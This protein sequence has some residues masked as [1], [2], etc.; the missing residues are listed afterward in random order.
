METVDVIIPLYKP[1]AEIFQILSI[2]SLQTIRPERIIL[3]NT[4]KKYF[5]ELTKEDNRFEKYDNLSVF[6]ISFDEFD[7]GDTRNMGAS[8]SNAD[9]FIMMTQDALPENNRLIEELLKGIK[10]N[11]N[12]A[13]SYARQLPREDCGEAE[14]FARKFNYPDKPCLK[15]KTD[16][17]TLGIKAFFCS[18]V[19]AMYDSKIFDKLGGFVHKAIFNEDMLYAYKALMSGYGVYYAAKAQVIHSH[20]YSCRQQFH[21]NFDLGVSQADH[22][23]VFAAVSSESEGI[24]FAFDTCA[25]LA[26]NAKAYLIPH[27]IFLCI[28]RYMGYFLGKRYKALPMPFVLKCTTNRV[29]FSKRTDLS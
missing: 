29:Y 15:T 23:E 2:L 10:Q 12:V 20:N 17:E 13:V 24:S 6:H 18:D 28:S 4:E 27:F 26:K 19:C 14:R 8:I 7:H 21:R 5:D 22:P 1:S 25:H 9:Y 11:P 16:I 3:I